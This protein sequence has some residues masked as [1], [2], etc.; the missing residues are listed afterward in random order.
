MYVQY[1]SLQ[2]RRPNKKIK[3]LKSL[4]KEKY[5]FDSAANGRLSHAQHN[6]FLSPYEEVPG[7]NSRQGKQLISLGFL[8]IYYYNDYNK[9]E[10]DA[11]EI[12]DVALTV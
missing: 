12:H 5:S 10:F 3:L 4:K 8:L 6:F 1:L 2:F 11:L 7:S 9:S